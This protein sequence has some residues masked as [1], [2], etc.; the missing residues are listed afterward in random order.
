[1]QTYVMTS[2]EMMAHVQQTFM[3]IIMNQCLSVITCDVRAASITVYIITTCIHYYTACNKVNGLAIHVKFQKL[4]RHLARLT[5]IIS[6]GSI[7]M[8][9]CRPGFK[10]L[11]VNTIINS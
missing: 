3:G 10:K 5:R 4:I 7:S 8:N 1:M 9:Y 2:M 11:K 6:Q